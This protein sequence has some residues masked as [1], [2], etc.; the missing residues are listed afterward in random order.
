MFGAPVLAALYAGAALVAGLWSAFPMAVLGVLLVIVAA[1]LGRVALES[2]EGPAEV[3]VVVGTGV[4]ALIANVGTAFL[5]A[6]VAHAGY[7]RPR[8][9]GGEL[10]E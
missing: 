7:E 1:H 3:V 9:Q 10:V 4:A 2:V 5:L 6:A 8:E